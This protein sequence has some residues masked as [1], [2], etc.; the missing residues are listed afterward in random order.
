MEDRSVCWGMKIKMDDGSIK[1]STE[2]W[3]SKSEAVKAVREFNKKHK[4]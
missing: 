1:Y 4:K 3:P 2:T